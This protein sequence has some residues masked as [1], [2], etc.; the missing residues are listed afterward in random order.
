[1]S[2]RRAVLAVEYAFD[3]GAGRRWKM[4]AASAVY[5]EPGTSTVK[6]RVAMSKTGLWADAYYIHA[7][8]ETIAVINAM[9]AGGAFDR[10]RFIHV[11]A[12]FSNDEDEQ[13]SLTSLTMTG[14]WL[15][16]TFVAGGVN[17]GYG[18]N[19]YA[20]KVPQSARGIVIP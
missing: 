1:M 7:V 13:P 6:F 18:Y 14:E 2:D 11:E 20:P 12:H 3:A 4:S 10:D 5:S 15:P 16:D 17:T 8:P 9:A 19:R